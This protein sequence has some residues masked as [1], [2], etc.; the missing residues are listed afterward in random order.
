MRTVSHVGLDNRIFT[1]LS[2]VKVG[3]V[4]VVAIAALGSL[5]IIWKAYHRFMPSIL[6]YGSEHK[7]NKVV[8]VFSRFSTEHILEKVAT[9]LVDQQS[10]QVLGRF[11]SSVQIKSSTYSTLIKRTIGQ[12]NV[13]SFIE[14]LR[15]TRIEPDQL[16]DKLPLRFFQQIVADQ[17]PK[18]QGRLL[19][20]GALCALPFSNELQPH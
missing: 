6:V 11:L 7:Y 15:S 16:F 10:Q 20:N 8:A 5:E 18:L 12:D 1:A 2:Q 3:T 14:L 4:L 9:K 17:D 19:K 13:E